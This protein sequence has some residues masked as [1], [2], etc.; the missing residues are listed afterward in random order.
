MALKNDGCCSWIGGF[1]RSGNTF[2]IPLIDDSDPDDS[3]VLT[4]SSTFACYN[5]QLSSLFEF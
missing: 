1:A 4:F 5:Y 2:G 3:V